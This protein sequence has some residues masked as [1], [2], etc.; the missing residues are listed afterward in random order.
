M[1]ETQYPKVLGL[2]L[3][4]YEAQQ[5]GVLPAWNRFLRSSP[6]GF[7]VNSHLTDGKLAGLDLAGGYYDAGDTMKYTLPLGVSMSMLAWGGVQFKSAYVATGQMEALWRTV[8]WGVDWLV[9]AHFKASDVA[10]QNQLV[11]QVGCCVCRG[12]GGD[13]P[14]RCRGCS[15]WRVGAW[16]WCR[17]EGVRQSISR[18]TASRTGASR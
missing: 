15:Q 17:G 8:K 7:R 18:C 13:A 9:K 6:G 5:S 14:G 4:F 3:Q 16:G 12:G 2:A 10:A 1:L 11:V